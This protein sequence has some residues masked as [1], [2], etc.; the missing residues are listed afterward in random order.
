[1]SEKIIHWRIAKV[2]KEIAAEC[3]EALAKENDFHRLNRSMGRYVRRNWQ[4]YIPFARQA[5]TSILTKDFAMEIALG[6]YTAQGVEEMKMEVY[7]CLVIDGA[8]KAPAQ[9]TIPSIAM[10]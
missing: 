2:A 3:Y 5:L 6:T 1:V 10:H 7:E 8:H 4:H 9:Q